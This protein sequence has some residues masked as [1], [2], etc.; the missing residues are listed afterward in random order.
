[1]AII[2]LSKLQTESRNG[3]TTAIDSVSTLEMCSIINQ[4]DEGVTEAVR[5]CLPQVAAA[6][7]ATAPRVREGGRLIYVGAGTSGR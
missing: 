5:K 6:I 2:D 3:N 1:M 7:D 4:E